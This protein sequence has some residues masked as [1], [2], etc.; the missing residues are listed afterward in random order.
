MTMKLDSNF[1]D[2]ITRLIAAAKAQGETDKDTASTATRRAWATLGLEEV[3]PPAGSLGL[4]FDRE[5]ISKLFNR[6]EAAASYKDVYT[7]VDVE[8]DTR[9]G[10]AV[11]SKLQSDVLSSLE[12]DF[13]SA[14]GTAVRSRIHAAAQQVV[15]GTDRGTTG[16]IKRYAGLLIS[17]LDAK[18]IGTEGIPESTDG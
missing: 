13:R 18:I 7:N 12:R 2:K 4:L 17:E 3:T 8:A 16:N 14:N 9:L 5:E 1:E 11:V 15:A 6:D 10:I